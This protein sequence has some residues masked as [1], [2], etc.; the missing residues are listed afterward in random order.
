MSTEPARFFGELSSRDLPVR[1][2]LSG[3]I[4]IALL[5]VGPACAAGAAQSGMVHSQVLKVIRLTDDLASGRPLVHL[6]LVN[7]LR[8][9]SPRGN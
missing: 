9:Q 8:L 7:Y 1:F 6:E 3:V 4:T 2:I 5:A